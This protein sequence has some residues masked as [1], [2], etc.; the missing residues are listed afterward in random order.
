[1]TAAIIVCATP[2]HKRWGTV[3]MS[4]P[5]GAAFCLTSLPG[6]IR[7]RPRSAPMVGP[8]DIRSRDVRHAVEGLVPGRDHR[9]FEGKLNSYRPNTPKA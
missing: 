2:K 9:P 4:T 8:G 7:S 1:M 3:K 5:A 6:T